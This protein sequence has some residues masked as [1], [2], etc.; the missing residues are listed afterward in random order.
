M[1]KR[2]R[3]E[4]LKDAKKIAKALK[5]GKGAKAK[6]TVTLTDELGNRKTEKLLVKLK[7]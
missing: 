1:Y 3:R 4:G 6:L 2:Q 5:R 7:R